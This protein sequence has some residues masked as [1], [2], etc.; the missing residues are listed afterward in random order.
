MGISWYE[1]MAHSILVCSLVNISSYNVSVISPLMAPLAYKPYSEE[2]KINKNNTY[3][4]IRLFLQAM[5]R[6][7]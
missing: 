1:T 2:T 7:Q 5:W 4:T 6:K 3:T